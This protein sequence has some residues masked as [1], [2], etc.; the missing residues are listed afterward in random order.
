MTQWFTSRVCYSYNEWEEQKITN[1]CDFQQPKNLWTVTFTRLGHS[2]T[3]IGQVQ[4]LF[5]FCC[6]TDVKEL[7]D[8]LS[9]NTIKKLFLD[10][11][12]LCS[13]ANTFTISSA[14]KAMWVVWHIRNMSQ[15]VNVGLVT[16]SVS[17]QRPLQVTFILNNLNG[18]SV[19]CM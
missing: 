18:W 9:F 6:S 12:F 16:V 11:Y 7:E 13:R 14:F 3:S 8:P 17:S 5:N 4:V 2:W 15:M 19:P 10:P 1:C